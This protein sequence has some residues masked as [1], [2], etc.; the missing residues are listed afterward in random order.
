MDLSFNLDQFLTLL[1]GYNLAIWPLQVIAYVLGIAALLLAALKTKYSGSLIMAILAFFWL[2]TGAVFNLVYFRPFYPL[3]I[4][5]VFLFV[6]QGIIFAAAAAGKP[7]L[8][9]SFQHNAR[10]FTAK[11]MALYAL[12]G[13]PLLEMFLGRGY[14]RTLPFG[15]V[16]CPTTIFTL[17]ILLLAD[18]KLPWYVFAIPVLYSFGGIVPIASG[19]YE[20][21]GLVTGGLLALF[22]LLRKGKKQD[23]HP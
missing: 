10:T 4:V 20:D 2:W 13:Y 7:Q 21:I 19:I 15:L 1:Q 17:A 18:K 3:A 16:P 5:F 22:F 9:F 12:V 6:I 23:Q 8:S 11:L 14:P